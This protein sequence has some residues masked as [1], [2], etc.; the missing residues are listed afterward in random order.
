[1]T[2]QACVH[3]ANTQQISRDTPTGFLPLLEEREA[4]AD[5]HVINAQRD[6]VSLFR[7]ELKCQR[8]ENN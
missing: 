1:M 8:R 4:D 7:T 5:G 2:G 3:H 6:G